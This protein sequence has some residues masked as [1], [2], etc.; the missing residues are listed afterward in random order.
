MI[1]FGKFIFKAVTTVAIA[2]LGIATVV[3]KIFDEKKL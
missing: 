2:S 1:K 3:V